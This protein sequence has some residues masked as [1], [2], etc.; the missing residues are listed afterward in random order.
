MLDAGR[1][2][3][4]IAREMMRRWGFRPRAAWRY[5]NGLSQETAAGLFNAR[6]DT[7]GRAPM[8]GTR[9]SA[10]ERWP[11]SGERPRLEVLRGLAVIY[12][13][14]LTHLVDDLD[15]KHLPESHRLTMLE[16]IQAREARDK[17]V[18]DEEPTTYAQNSAPGDGLPAAE[19]EVVTLVAHE[20]SEHAERAERRDIGE[21]TLEQFRADVSRLAYE[22]LTGEPF[23]LL[24]EMRRVRARIYSALEKRLW[25]RD[26]TELYFL[27]AAL[28]GLMANASQDLGVTPASDELF[29]AGWAY[30]IAIDHR[31]LM[32]YLRGATAN[33]A[34]W[35]G[36][37]RH[38]R[39]LAASALEY[40][41]DGH[42]AARLHLVHGRAAAALGDAA[43]A[44]RSIA[45]ARDAAERPNH[46]DI[47]DGL[48]GEYGCAASKRAYLAGSTLADLRGE[49]PA[50]IDALLEATA[51]FAAEPESERSYGCEAIAHINLAQTQ[52]RSG[53]LEAVDLSLVFGLPHSRRIDALEKAFSGVRRELA[54]P[55]YHGNPLAAELD[56][57]IETFIRDTITHDLR[58]LP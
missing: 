58:E 40:H 29:R 45:A 8:T 7:D 6:Y 53:D 33:A 11:H 52:L 43:T 39:D 10:F 32:G 22:Y 23:A 44:R 5:A 28:N 55:R 36:R 9:I 14:D 12:E 1:S 21:A 35:Q 56:E 13:T 54:T 27:L 57:R 51:L 50:A 37:P 26:Q 47:H 34:Y 25:P 38:A 4:A 17:E 24:M 2:R 48:G 31:P 46:D 15:L 18:P 49:E 41:S 19:R 16:L 20:S 3:R 30:A 42:G